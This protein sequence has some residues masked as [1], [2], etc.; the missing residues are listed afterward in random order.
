MANKT[1]RR[2]TPGEIPGLFLTQAFLYQQPLGHTKCLV[3]YYV[4][5]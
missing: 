5:K 3:G 1:H 4:P 2:Q